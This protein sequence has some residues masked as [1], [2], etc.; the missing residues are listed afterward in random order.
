MR[1]RGQILSNEEETALTAEQQRIAEDQRLALAE[2][3]LRR[4]FSMEQSR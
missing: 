3:G 4:G 2:Q 1:P